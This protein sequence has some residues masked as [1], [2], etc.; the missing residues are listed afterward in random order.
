MPASMTGRNAVQRSCRLRSLDRTGTRARLPAGAAPSIRRITVPA[1]F[2]IIRVE[3]SDG[4]ANGMQQEIQSHTGDA[5]ATESILRSI[6][7]FGHDASILSYEIIPQSRARTRH[8]GQAAWT[9][10]AVR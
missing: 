1:S 2:S 6:E 9:V 7:R 4:S 10:R 3:H 5:G 8:T